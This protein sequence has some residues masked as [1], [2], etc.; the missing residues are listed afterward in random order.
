MSALKTELFNKGINRFDTDTALT[1]K[2]A[3]YFYEKNS[4]I[5]EGITKS[6]FRDADLF[7]PMK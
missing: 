7:T 1:N 4:F 2:V 3:Q 6:Y 5:K